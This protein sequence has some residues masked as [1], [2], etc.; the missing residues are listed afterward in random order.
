MFLKLILTLIGVSLKHSHI[1][2]DFNFVLHVKVALLICVSGYF[3]ISD[4]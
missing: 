3:Y 2:T 4:C 1:Y